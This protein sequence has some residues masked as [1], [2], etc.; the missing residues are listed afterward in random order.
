MR[1][2]DTVKGQVQTEYA[3]IASNHDDDSNLLSAAKS[4]KG[5]LAVD[6][7]C[8]KWL[9]LDKKKKRKLGSSLLVLGTG[10]G[11]VLALDIS[12]GQLKWRAA[13]SHPGGVSAISF[14]S[15]STRVYSAGAD[16]MVCEIDPHTG[17]LL[18]KFKASTKAISFMSVSPDGKTLATAAGQLKTFSCS[19]HKKMQKFCG[20]PGGVRYMVFSEDGK[21]IL[22]SAVGERYVAIWSISGGKKQSASCVLAMEHP[23]IFIDSKCIDNDAGLYV[24]AISETGDCY[25][26][27]GK[28]IEE[29]RYAKPTKVSSSSEDVASK[30]SVF[31]AKL[32]AVGKQ[33]SVHAFVAHGL[34]IKPLFQ[35]ITIHSGTDI[36]LSSSRDGVLLPMSQSLG[37]S[38]KGSE[39]KNRVTA[40]DRAN[41]EDALHPVPKIFDLHDKKNRLQ[42]FNADPDEMMAD[43]DGRKKHAKSVNKKDDV[44]EM[45]DVSETF[46]EDKLR[47]LG[48][49]GYEDDITFKSELN[50]TKSM[51]IDLETTLPPKKIR[52]AVLAMEPSDAF[53]LLGSLVAIWQSRSCHGE[54]VLP[55]VH[56]I[57]I[58]HGHCA[59]SQE[60]AANILNSLFKICKSRGVAIQQLLQLSGRLNLVTAQ[61]DKAV[62]IGKPVAVDDDTDVSDDDEEEDVDDLFYKED[63]DESQISSD[64][65]E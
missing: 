53:K 44:V 58:H 41:A 11:D 5:H 1:I 2:W 23:A 40:L 59:M 6:Y 8:I 33:A 31:A 62:K 20:H 10:G 30:T 26:W 52:A 60:P 3:D 49:L 4:R 29:L 7:T 55:W 48:I 9:S 63:E 18:G 36:M 25:I 28:D 50:Y 14:S 42:N 39:T 19:N 15:D 56:S 13:D 32:Q 47:S 16:G 38:K 24:L 17:N 64:D 65:E 45:E 43:V 34:L 37:K 21:Y 61:I 35:K 27:S 54:S 51:G 12:A 57:L 46:M 22:S